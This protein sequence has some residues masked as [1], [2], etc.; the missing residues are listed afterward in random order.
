MADSSA[1]DAALVAKLAADATWMAFVPDGV[2]MDEAPPGSQRFVI[3]SL[4]D[5]SDDQMLG[6]RALEDALYLV[7]A[8]SLSTA[9]G[10][11]KSAAARIDVLLEQGSLTV[12]G[13]AISCMRR[14][15]RVRATEVDEI[16][17]SLRWNHRGGQ[18]RV[19]AST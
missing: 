16:D 3:V 11:V 5:E 2:Y 8:V 7:K 18:Y 1:I 6:G 19:V 15:A 14:E 12:S 10:D 17:P 4:I 13:Y 9:G